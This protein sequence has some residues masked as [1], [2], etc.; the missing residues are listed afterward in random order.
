[1]IPERLKLARLAAGLTLRELAHKAGITAAAI[2]KYERGEDMPRQSTTL[3]LARALGILPSVLFTAPSVSLAEVEFRKKASLPESKSEE[4]RA[5]VKREL[6]TYIDFA[7]LLPSYGLGRYDS[8]LANKET[9]ESLEQ[10]EDYVDGLRSGLGLGTDP[11]RNVT[12]IVEEAG[13]K[14]LSIDGDSRFDEMACIANNKYPAL[15][16]KN[17]DPGKGDRQRFNVLHGLGHLLLCPSQGIDKEKVCHRFAGAML[18]PREAAIRKLGAKRRYLDLQY[19][20]PTLKAEFGMSIQAWLFRAFDLK[21]IDASTRNMLFADMSQRGWRKNE[22]VD[23]AL[24][25]PTRFR[26]MVSRARAEGALSSVKAAEYLEPWERKIR[27]P[28]DSSD[29]PLSAIADY[30]P[31]GALDSWSEGTASGEADV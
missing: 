8:T 9:V 22:P 21:I 14:V 6:E 28:L 25:V 29:V 13:V 24:E 16:I 15:V 12:E 1:M 5:K 2:S 19:E 31:G 30:L 10:V 18:A 7:E 27:P 4:I 20:L 3:A 17:L 23:I 11:I 26:L